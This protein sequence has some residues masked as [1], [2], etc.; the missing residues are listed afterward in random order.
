MSVNPAHEKASFSSEG[1][2]AGYVFWFWRL[3]PDVAEKANLL[4]HA[5]SC[6]GVNPFVISEVQKAL[7]GG[8]LQME[9]RA[10]LAVLHGSCAFYHNDNLRLFRIARIDRTAARRAHDVESHVVD[11]HLRSSDSDRDTAR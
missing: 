6:E 4:R 1:S 11:R 8:Y 3:T 5:F 2:R 9:A 7:D 10:R